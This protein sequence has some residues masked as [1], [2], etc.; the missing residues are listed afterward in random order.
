MD[1]QNIVITPEAANNLQ[2]PA[3]SHK[4]GEIPY[5]L[6]ASDVPLVTIGAGRKS[7]GFNLKELW[8]YREL[9][10]FLTLR[11]IKVR[12]KQTALGVLWV[13]GQPLL[14]T[15][16]FTIFLGVLARVPSDGSP[17]PLLV[18]VGLLPWM[19]FSNAVVYSAASIV[20]N[21]NLITKVYFPRMAIPIAAV[22]ARLIDFAVALI[23]LI[24][25]M[26]YYQVA[27][28]WRLTMMP[29]LILLVTILAISVGLLTSALN[30]KYRDVGVI[31]PVVMQL[32]MFV[33]PVIY[34]SRLVLDR[35]PRAYDV[36]ALNPMVGVIDGF[37]SAILGQPF[38]LYSLAV[39]AVFSLIIMA[40]AIRLFRRV[41][42]EFADVI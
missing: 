11:D 10:F 2:V 40:I 36:Y 9:L 35:S 25:M 18:Y 26:V 39:A 17:Y 29:P 1:H 27:I 13:I 34:A 41:E 30:V 16:I 33:S 22:M 31:L 7:F 37:R 5:E 28:T 21:S 14:I 8:R 15:I 42:R 3:S 6:H 12:Y 38:K 24:G 32:W 23:I 19:F 20:G 4:E